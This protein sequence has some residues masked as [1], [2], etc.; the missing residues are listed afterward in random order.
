MLAEDFLKEYREELVS[1]K[2]EIVEELDLIRTKVREN[3]KFLELLE[4]DD[5]AVFTEFSPREISSKNSEKIKEVRNE[6]SA[7]CSKREELTE[8]L[9]KIE[10]KIEE[11][12]TIIETE[13]DPLHNLKGNYS[14]LGINSGQA[15][16]LLDSIEVEIRDKNKDK[17]SDPSQNTDEVSE[18][19]IANLPDEELLNVEHFPDME[20]DP[21]A[22][23]EE[24]R[25]VA[26]A[27]YL[28]MMSLV[29]A[30]KQIDG[31]ILSDPMR[32]KIELKQIAGELENITKLLE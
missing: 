18:E 14:R 1:K 12:N 19:D 10:K 9:S 15:R 25:S 28:E 23:E 31:Y 27:F 29:N 26:E 20:I 3:E 22:Y 2:M 13:F 11:I 16:Q 7:E 30:C 5:N 32:G 21:S 24:Q 6:L 8:K 4:T 17:T